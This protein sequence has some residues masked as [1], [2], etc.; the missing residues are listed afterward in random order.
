MESQVGRRYAE[1]LFEVARQQEFVGD[2]ENNLKV[3]VTALNSDPAFRKFMFAPQTSRDEKL[4]IA[5]KLFSEK[6]VAPAYQVI[7][8]M[9][10]KRRETDIESM[11][12]EFVKL[13]RESAGVLFATVTSA[14]EMDEKQ[15]AALIDSLKKKSGANVEAQFNVDPKLIGGV[16]I[17]YG[18]H[19]IDGSARGKLN[20]IGEM[21][22][23]DVLKQA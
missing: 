6:M 15:R 7:R 12:D 19:L 9:I 20:Q 1:A 4:A 18:N 11:V 8:L 2:V 10:E 23:R 21:F 13:R 22:R 14:I 5:E 3:V 17:A 16:K